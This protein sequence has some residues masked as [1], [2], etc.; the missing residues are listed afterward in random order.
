MSASA[1]KSEVLPF[2]KAA[3]ALRHCKREGDS[4]R[5]QRRGRATAPDNMLKTGLY[6]CDD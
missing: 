2:A 5:G 6:R 3:G 1:A 4:N